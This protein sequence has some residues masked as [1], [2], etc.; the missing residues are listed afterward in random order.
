MRFNQVLTGDAKGW[1]I[2]ESG[3]QEL[4]QGSSLAVQ[5]LKAPRSQCSRPRFNPW[6]GNWIAHVATKSLHA[7]TE[8]KKSIVF[9]ELCR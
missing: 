4:G 9:P 5:W 7:T 3:N 1:E 8:K 6:S 2:G